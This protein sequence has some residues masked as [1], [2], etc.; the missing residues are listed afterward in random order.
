MNV[1]AI[2]QHKQTQLPSKDLSVDWSRFVL[3]EC[4]DWSVIS[5]ERESDWAFAKPNRT[6]L[7]WEDS[8]RHSAFSTSFVYWSAQKKLNA[9]STPKRQPANSCKTLMSSLWYKIYMTSWST[10]KTAQDT[11]ERSLFTAGRNVYTLMA[12]RM[13][14]SGTQTS[15]QPPVE[16]ISTAGQTQ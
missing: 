7:K 8:D 6:I 3:C 1:C 9:K 10:S 4:K 2:V 12:A 5:M 11:M 14:L 15:K 16:Y 13:N